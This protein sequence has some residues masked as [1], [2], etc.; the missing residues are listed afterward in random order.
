METLIRVEKNFQVSEIHPS[1][2][3]DHNAVKLPLTITVRQRNP[4]KLRLV[5]NDRRVRAPTRMNQWSVVVFGET[6]GPPSG[7]TIYRLLRG[8]HTPIGYIHN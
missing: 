7:A 4:W 6:V 5:Y 8:F 2:L 3:T 1:S